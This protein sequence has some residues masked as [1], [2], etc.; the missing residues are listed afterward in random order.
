MD[1]WGFFVDLL[2][3]VLREIFRVGIEKIEGRNILVVA[4]IYL[5]IYLFI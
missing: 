3:F 2:K 4:F 5:F 1:E